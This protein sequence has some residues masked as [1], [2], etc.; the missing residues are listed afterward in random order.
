MKL[1]TTLPF[2]IKSHSA[3]D[4]VLQFLDDEDVVYSEGCPTAGQILQLHA[5]HTQHYQVLCWWNSA[6]QRLRRS[7]EVPGGIQEELPASWPCTLKAK[8][9]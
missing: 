3:L 2:V 8:V 7:E 4:A 9:G 5:M 1:M 6:K